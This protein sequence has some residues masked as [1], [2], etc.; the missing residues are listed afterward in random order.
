MLALS[1]LSSGAYTMWNIDDPTHTHT[2]CMGGGIH[3]DRARA[4]NNAIIN[5][6]CC[7]DIANVNQNRIGPRVCVSV[8]YEN[9]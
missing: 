6:M 1:T 3:W 7:Q 8:I 9:L 4:W 2:Q 5:I